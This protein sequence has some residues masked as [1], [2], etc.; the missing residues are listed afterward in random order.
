MKYQYILFDLDDTLVRS[1]DYQIYLIR[2]S[3]RLL[4][5]TPVSDAFIHAYRT[6][7]K[8]QVRD[9]LQMCEALLPCHGEELKKIT[10]QI[11]ANL[12]DEQITNLLTVYP[13]MHDLLEKLRNA[14]V[15]LGI[16]TGKPQPEA[17]RVIKL[18]NLDLYFQTVVT[19]DHV[20]KAKPDPEG[21]LLALRALGMP[22]TELS[23]RDFPS[24]VFIGDS[25]DEYL[26]A[27]K[28]HIDYIAAFWQWE[29][30]GIGAQKRADWEKRGHTGRYALQTDQLEQYL[31][32]R[33]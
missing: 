9:R 16:V 26:M 29:E 24:A 4:T 10:H 14:Q 20:Q 15:K 1:V 31:Q 19:R 8:H 7:I 12:T 32:L 33:D 30:D 3:M 27:Q 11:A 18:L 28:L 22:V 21:I 2:E 13:G 6:H 5:G 25:Y 23:K 17:K